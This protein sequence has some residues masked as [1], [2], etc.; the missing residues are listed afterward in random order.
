[1]KPPCAHCGKPVTKSASQIRRSQKL[2]RRMFC[3][4]ECRRLWTLAIPVSERFD[5]K[6][7]KGAPNGCWL[8]TASIGADGYARFV[9]NGK[10]KHAHRVSMILAGH[11]VPADMDVD[12]CVCRIRHCVN[13]A[14]LRVATQAQNALENNESPFAKNKRKTHCKRGHPLSGDNVRI[15]MGKSPRGGV[16]TNRKCI[17]CY[18]PGGIRRSKNFPR[19]SP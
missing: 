10:V 14:H 4:I 5:A 7:N 18:G 8:W 11:D 13:P 15:V 9:F 6:V 16:T 1:M 17:A 3:G 19:S 12:H 2:G